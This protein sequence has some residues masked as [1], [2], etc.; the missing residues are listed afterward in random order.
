MLIIEP[1]AGLSNRILALATGYHL[2]RKYNH[3]IKLLW[4]VDYTV[5]AKIQDLFELPKDIKII[6]MTKAPIHQFPFLKLKSMLMR[7]RYEKQCD[8]SLNCADVAENLKDCGSEEALGEI[9]KTYN[10]IY[11]KAY[12][13]LYKIEDKSIFS[14]FK[15]SPTIMHK[16][17]KVFDEIGEQTIGMHIRR[18]DHAEAIKRSPTELFIKKAEQLFT[19]TDYSNLFLATDDQNIEE[20]FKK[21]FGDKIIFYEGK[22]FTRRNTSGMEDSVVDLLALARC[23]II[24]GSYGSTFSLMA[25]YIGN[26]ELIILEEEE[27]L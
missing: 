21:M 19:E 12:C 26:S 14:I 10:R 4:D 2:A 24:Y 23:R 27:R 1:C 7:S 9:F 22:N 6:T 16:G 18:T 3:E 8:I 13:E 17:C 25:S 11:I 15:I 5:G 20:K